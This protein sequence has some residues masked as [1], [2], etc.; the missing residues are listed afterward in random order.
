[1]RF[2]LSLSS[3]LQVNVMVRRIEKTDNQCFNIKKTENDYRRYGK[4]ARTGAVN[5]FKTERAQFQPSTLLA[6]VI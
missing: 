2:L 1:M 4:K 5:C 3:S 6:H